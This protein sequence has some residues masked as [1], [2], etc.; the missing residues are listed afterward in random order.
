MATRVITQP[1]YSEV[2]PKKES[3][4]SRGSRRGTATLIL[5]LLGLFAGAI[6]YSFTEQ[7]FWLG[8]MP[9]VGIIAG[10][11]FGRDLFYK[12]KMEPKIL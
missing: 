3:S 10:I 9:I 2:K 6:I 5:G 12:K 1:T 8:V 7:S 11:V 4:E